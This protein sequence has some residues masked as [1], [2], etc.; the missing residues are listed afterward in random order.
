MY[1]LNN[2][3]RTITNNADK[4]QDFEYLGMTEFFRLK[5]NALHYLFDIIQNEYRNQGWATE[6]RVGSL[7]C[8]KSKI[9]AEGKREVT[10]ILIKVEK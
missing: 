9:T 4:E 6:V 1:K 3:A 8:Y 10:E 5:K 7:Y 2:Y